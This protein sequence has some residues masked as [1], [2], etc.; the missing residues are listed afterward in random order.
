[1][2]YIDAIF[3]T[4]AQKNCFA[5]LIFQCQFRR[6]SDHG[7]GFFNS[8]NV[9]IEV[10]NIRPARSS[11]VSGGRHSEGVIQRSI[12]IFQIVARF[13]TGARPLKAKKL[14]Y[15][16]EPIFASRL[17]ALPQPEAR[18][19]LASPWAAMR[20]LGLRNTAPPSAAEKAPRREGAVARAAARQAPLRSRPRPSKQQAD[21]LTLIDRPAAPPAPASDAPAPPISPPP[22]PPPPSA[23]RVGFDLRPRETGGGDGSEAPS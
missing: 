21:L 6:F 16:K 17:F 13:V 2:R 10:T 23:E 1:M 12:P 15:D 3:Q 5:L 4:Q 8:F 20:S 19:P 9:M 7:F 14:R 22:E 11:I 18:A